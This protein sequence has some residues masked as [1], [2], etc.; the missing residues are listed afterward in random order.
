MTAILPVPAD[1]ASRARAP[2]LLAGGLAL[3]LTALA[4]V[5]ASAQTPPPSE[6]ADGFVHVSVVLEGQEIGV[7]FPPDLAANEPAYAELLAGIPVHLGTF[8]RHRALRMGTL[9]AGP[10]GAGRG[11]G[12]G[13]GASGS[14]GAGGTGGGRAG[15]GG[16]RR[17]SCTGRAARSRAVDRASRRGLALEIRTSGAGDGDGGTVHVVPLNHAE[18]AAAPVFTASVHATAAETGRLVLRWGRQ[19]WSSDFRFEEL[20]P[21]PRRPR[22]S[23]R[24]T[25]RQ[26]SDDNSP[27]A[28]NNM[29]SERNETALVLP[30][31]ARISMLYWK[32]I[33]VED[34]DYPT[35]AE[36]ADGAVVEMIRAPVLRLKSDV[37]LRFGEADVTTGNLAPG[38]AGAYGV[39]LRKAGAGWRFVFNHEPDSWGTQH[40][41]DFDAAETAVEYSRAAG[42]FRP[43]GA[44]LV[45]TGPD[46]GRLVVHWGPHEWAAD[47]T[48]VREPSDAAAVLLRPGAV[49]RDCPSCPVRSWWCNLTGAWRSVATRSHGASTQL[50]RARPN[51]PGAADATCFRKP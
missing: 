27:T 8:E 42:S 13:R 35:L 43:L 28:R 46:R 1:A 3:G 51:T 24:G 41:P 9:E 7:S 30:D 16:R 39:W 49:F 15:S 14:R 10:R 4:A 31:G 12:R 33:D 22:V 2:A 19:A 29:L 37:S 44:T 25:P 21:P 23:G 50:S 11:T 45:P 40:D 26:A 6:E 20:P 47:F 34:E 36:T 32:G 17:A 5:Q 38:F 18:T 48:V